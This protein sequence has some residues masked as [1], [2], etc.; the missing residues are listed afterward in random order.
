M[1]NFRQNVPRVLRT[2]PIVTILIKAENENY[3][4]GKFPCG[5][6]SPEIGSSI[7]V[8]NKILSFPTNS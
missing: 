4:D 2:R 7:P 6:D 8:Q 3:H 5:T 1:L